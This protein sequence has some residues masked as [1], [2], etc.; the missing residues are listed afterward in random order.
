MM[1]LAGY[2]LAGG[3]NRRMD[4]RKK[5]FLTYREKSFY[6]W[7]RE[8]MDSLDT[9]YVSVEQE[10]PYEEVKEKLI[11]DQFEDAGPVGGILSGLLSCS[12]DALLTVPCDMVPFPAD[13]IEHMISIYEVQKTPLVIKTGGRELPFPGIYTKSMIPVLQQMICQHQYRARDIWERVLG[14]Y[15]VLSLE[16]YQISNINTRDEYRALREEQ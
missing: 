1:K 7:L 6:E 10:E 14:A 12:E 8:G 15:T 4:G 2:I 3:K 5:L 13:I 9:I 11:V 16:D